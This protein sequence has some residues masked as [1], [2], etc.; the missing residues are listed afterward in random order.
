MLILIKIRNFIYILGYLAVEFIRTV[1][2][3][4]RSVWESRK[5]LLGAV[6]YPLGLAVF[7]TLFYWALLE[8]LYESIK[9]IKALLCD[10]PAIVIAL[11]CMS[12]FFVIFE[13]INAFVHLLCCF[14]HWNKSFRKI[15]LMQETI[16]TC[17]MSLA[18]IGA[19]WIA[20]QTDLKSHQISQ[21][22][23]ILFGSALIYFLD[24]AFFKAYQTI[25]LKHDRIENL[26]DRIKEKANY[27][28][29]RK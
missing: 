21:D 24:F 29:E 17:V 10:P 15:C 25:F 18:S 7:S 9:H 1:F 11:L 4:F 13:T 19:L 14:I 27:L 5:I 26:Y 16:G 8:K 23:F 12:L 2:S 3:A 28:R 6:F 20:T 22:N